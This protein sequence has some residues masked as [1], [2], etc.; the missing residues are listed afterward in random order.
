MLNFLVL[1]VVL[2]KKTRSRFEKSGSIELEPRLGP[3]FNCNLFCPITKSS[4]RRAALTIDHV[5]LIFSSTSCPSNNRS[6]NTLRLKQT[7]IC[8]KKRQIRAKNIGP[9]LVSYRG[10][11]KQK[12]SKQIL[13]FTYKIY[14]SESMAVLGPT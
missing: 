9:Q 8:L 14:L 2:S 10:P 6:S 1:S 7:T 11:Y 3:S 4:F 5:K 12:A 13:D